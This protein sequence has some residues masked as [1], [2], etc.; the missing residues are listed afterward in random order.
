MSMKRKMT[1]IVAV[2][3]LVLALVPASISKA[4][5]VAYVGTDGVLTTESPSTG[6]LGILPG[7]FTLNEASD[8]AAVVKA[9]SSKVSYDVSSKTLTINGVNADDFSVWLDDIIV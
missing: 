9:L 1:A 4:E 7:C 2:M 8:G 3:A 6:G 5:G